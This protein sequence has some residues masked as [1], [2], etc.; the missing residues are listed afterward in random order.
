[1]LN[2]T[3]HT[4]VRFCASVALVALAAFALSG[5]FGGD[6]KKA[7]F[8]PKAEAQPFGGPVPLKVKFTAQE[9]VIP[10][11]VSYHWCFDDGTV[12]NEQNPTHVFKEPGYYLVAVDIEGKKLTHRSTRSLYLGAW[13]PKLW[14]RAQKGFGAR[15][16]KNNIRT[17]Q[18]RSQRRKAELKRRERQSGPSPATKQPCG[19]LSKFGPEPGPNKQVPSGTTGAQSPGS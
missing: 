5:C 15:T 4:W 1:V 13:P 14:A 8:D 7:K 9:G 19:Q 2:D 16:I 6:D 17:Q 3:P 11:D 10:G 12:S 18:R